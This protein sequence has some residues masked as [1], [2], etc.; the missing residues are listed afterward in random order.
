MQVVESLRDGDR[1]RQRILRHFGVAMDDDECERL[2]QL[3]EYVRANLTD[4]RQPT[5]FPPEN[6]AE[7]AIGAGRRG[8]GK[9]ELRVDFKQLFEERRVVTGVHGCTGRATGNWAWTVYC[10]T[11]DTGPPMTRCFTR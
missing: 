10:R 11:R 7:M 2:K 5:L 8:D 1:V 3:W 4:E 9:R 6:L